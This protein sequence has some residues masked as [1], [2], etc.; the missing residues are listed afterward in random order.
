MA[1]FYSQIRIPQPGGPG[2]RIYIPQEQNGAVTSLGTG[3][4]MKVRVTLRLAV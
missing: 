4:K 1:I 3:L 2:A